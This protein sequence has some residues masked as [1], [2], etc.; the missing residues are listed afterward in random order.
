MDLSETE[1]TSSSP[2]PFAALPRGAAGPQFSP[3]GRTIAY[4]QGGQI[5]LAAVDSPASPV[6]LC[7]GWAP[8]WRPGRNELLVLRAERASS[9]WLQPPISGAAGAPI[10]G[11][12]RR[13]AAYAWSPDGRQ[14]ALVE[15]RALHKPGALWLIDADA[16]AVERRVRLSSYEVEGPLQWSPDG[17]WLAWSVEISPDDRTNA[18]HEIRVLDLNGGAVRRAVPPG[19]CQTAAPVWRPDGRA[20][21]LLATPHP[22]GF[23]ALYRLATW[24][25]D[26][27]AAR[28]L[29]RDPLV[30]AGA[31]WSPDGQ[32]LYLSACDRGITQ[33]L[34]A[35][36]VATGVLR[37]LTDG[38]RSFAPPTVS[39]DGRWLASTVTAP[40]QLAEVWLVAA[41]G[42]RARPI[43]V[44]SRQLDAV[45]NLQLGTPA[46][47]R[48]RGRD[49]LELEGLLLFPPPYGP[50]RLPPEPLPTVVDL[51]GG[52]IQPVSLGL[53]EH[54]L[55]LDGLH[56]LAARGYLCFAADY[57]R[58]GSYGWAP[59]QAALDS[60]DL[61][62]DDAD[63][64]LAGVAHLVA[65][66][67]ADPARLGLRGFSHGGLLANW[68]A[69]TSD[70]FQAVVSI[71]GPADL[72]HG[73]LDTILEL[74]LGGRPDEV[75]IHYRRCSPLAQVRSGRPPMLLLYSEHSVFSRRGEGGR[76]AAALRAVGAA[77]ELLTLPGEG[78]MFFQ[79][80]HRQLLLDRT[81]AWFDRHLRG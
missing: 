8:R 21:A 76:F 69:A 62:G 65:Q 61:I 3:D 74:W 35:L 58:S 37:R 22:Y 67:L 38:L 72:T 9:L 4:M 36:D 68:L 79:P 42:T 47:V 18:L 32:R 56:D 28:Y 64:I 30:V 20:L 7:A 23:Q 29:T 52:P 63:D 31:A 41:D 78:H 14:L 77:V 15:R 50:D 71:E 34:Y 70:R 24:H 44:A 51:H 53:G 48:W 43:S 5:S 40:D 54:P 59:L 27:S 26:G 55:Y 33:Q 46:L 13:I 39:P 75:P 19:A 60:A 49:G 1:R 17:R 2:S 45:P 66:G 80:A 73:E 10:P 25:V 81:A 16:G 57:R 12:P 11:A 6:Q